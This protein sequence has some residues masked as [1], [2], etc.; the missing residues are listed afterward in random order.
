ME[1]RG[2]CG[3]QRIQGASRYS[4]QGGPRGYLFQGP[5]QNDEVRQEVLDGARHVFPGDLDHGHRVSTE[6]QDLY[7][8]IPPVQVVIVRHRLL[9]KLLES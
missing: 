2:P 1:L 5:P 6:L 4:Y 7:F 3:R 9:E 8:M